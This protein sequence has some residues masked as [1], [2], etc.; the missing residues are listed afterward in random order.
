[1]E[2]R[3]IWIILQR[4]ATTQHK[5]IFFTRMRHNDEVAV[6]TAAES[7]KHYNTTAMSKVLSVLIVSFYWYC[8]EQI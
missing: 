1:M 8:V 5:V 6:H 7:R 4:E 3:V 2:N